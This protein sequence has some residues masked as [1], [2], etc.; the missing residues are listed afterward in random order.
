MDEFNRILKTSREMA[1]RFP[2]LV[3]IGGIAVW[4]YAV[5]DPHTRR[6]KEASHDI[7]FMI[8][9]SDLAALRDTDE[10]TP[11]KR[12][13][14]HH[15]IRDGIEFD[16]Y[17]E[18]NNKLIVPY[19]QVFAH[20]KNFGVMRVACLEH[21]FCLKLD[22]LADRK[23]TAKGDKDERDLVRIAMLGGRGMRKNLM[24]SYLREKQMKALQI[25]SRSQVFL[26]ITKGNAHQARKIEKE[27]EVVAIKLLKA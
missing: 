17:V 25:L 26:D 20:S 18:R 15:L 14:K 6:L 2:G 9:F 3:F 10:V 22:A 27:F 23:G 21:L 4:V 7:D 19:D 5:S 24:R 8:S 11:N 13:N 1:E 12:L 16:I